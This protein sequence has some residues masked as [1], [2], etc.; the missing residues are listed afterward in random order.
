M[1]HVICVGSGHLSRVLQ[2]SVFRIFIVVIPK[3]K[4]GTGPQQSFQHDTYFTI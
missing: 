3:E 2:K 4:W 1:Q